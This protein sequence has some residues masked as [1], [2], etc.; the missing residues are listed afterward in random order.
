MRC[1]S[2]DRPIPAPV[3]GATTYRSG[4]PLFSG[5]VC[6]WCM[7]TV[8]RPHLARMEREQKQDGRKDGAWVVRTADGL[9]VTADAWWLAHEIATSA[10]GEDMEEEACRLAED[11]VAGAVPGTPV[12]VAG[13]AWDVYGIRVPWLSAV[14]LQSPARLVPMSEPA[15]PVLRQDTVAGTVAVP[16]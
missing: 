4:E 3:S 9:T 2:C 10:L 8:V 15:L 14:L 11:T 7:E 5:P 16:L 6:N 1:A 13:R 12:P